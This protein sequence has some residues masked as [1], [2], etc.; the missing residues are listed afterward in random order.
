VVLKR[1]FVRALLAL[2]E[3]AEIKWIVLA[4]RID[5]VGK[6]IVVGDQMALIRVIPAV[7]Y[8]R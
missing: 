6:Q 1:R 2:A 7:S 3:A 4:T 8:L 5:V